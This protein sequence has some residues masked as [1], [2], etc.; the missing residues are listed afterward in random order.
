MSVRGAKQRQK[1]PWI[2]VSRV[3]LLIWAVYWCAVLLFPGSP[4]GGSLLGGALIQGVFVAAV[5][6]AMY[7]F[8]PTPDQ[9]SRIVSY[10]AC[11]TGIGRAAWVGLFLGT[12][13][14]ALMLYDRTWIQGVDF[15]DGLAAARVAWMNAGEGRTEISSIF[16][17][18]GYLLGGCYFAAAALVILRINDYPTA[19]QS[20]VLLACGLLVLVSSAMNGGRSSLM[21]FPA[22]C[23]PAFCLN[24]R[25]SVWK[26]LRSPPLLLCTAVAGAYSVNIFSSRASLGGDDSV[27][28]TLSTLE[29][30]L[31][32]PSPWIYSYDFPGPV[33][34]SILAWAYLIHS[35]TTTCLIAIEPPTQVIILGAHPLSMLAKLG[36]VSPPDQAW[37]LAGRFANVPGALYHQFGA[38]GLAVGSVLLGATASATIRALALFPRSLVALGAFLLTAAT[39]ALS[40]MCAAFDFLAYPSVAVGFM[41]LAPF[42]RSANHSSVAGQRPRGDSDAKR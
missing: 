25:T 2:G 41:V 21:L 12:I 8:K 35:F 9:S 40:P 20:L 13:G 23:L 38:V 1:V 28:Y 18:I 26:L 16:S 24:S 19:R 31:I 10:H 33:W 39:L 30:L 4:S 17:L 5:P 15:G 32:D 3:F 6:F 29:H 11:D 14:T 22:I 36:L 37:F 27:G 34:M 7:W 42:E